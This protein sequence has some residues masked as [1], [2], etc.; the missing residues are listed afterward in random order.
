M[1]TTTVRIGAAASVALTGILLT[2]VYGLAAGGAGAPRS[3]LR[4]ATAVKQPSLCKGYKTYGVPDVAPLNTRKTYKATVTTNKGV[5][6][7]TFY[8]KQAPVTVASFIFLAQHRYF[9]GVTFHRIVPTFVIQ[10]GDPTGTGICGPGYQFGTENTGG[11]YYR[12]TVAMARTSDPHSNG[13]QFFVVL[14]D[15]GP[16]N[17]EPNY[18]IFGKVTSG[19]NVVDRI[20]AVRLGPN[21]DGS[22]QSKPLE[23]VYMKS[24]RVTVN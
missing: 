20:A 14:Q 3:P 9:D 5:F 16:L 7:I 12:G 4:G 21:A 17:Q 8:P 13:S 11:K 6:T 23:K 2:G 19:M 15:N 10:G 18:S 22:E 24:V 1:A